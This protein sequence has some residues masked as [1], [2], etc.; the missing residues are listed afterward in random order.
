M[1]LQQLR[2]SPSPPGLRRSYF[3]TR[4][5]HWLTSS[6]T[7]STAFRKLLFPEI[8]LLSL[9]EHSSK[10]P[11]VPPGWWMNLDLVCHSIVLTTLLKASSLYYEVWPQQP[12]LGPGSS[13]CLSLSLPILPQPYPWPQST[14]HLSVC[15]NCW[16]CL[17]LLAL[18]QCSYGPKWTGSYKWN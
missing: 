1:G 8:A 2:D 4:H 7:G 14:R 15:C 3:S 6:R 16:H 12:L 13:R 18:P 9:T 10:S 5:A 17:R 11:H